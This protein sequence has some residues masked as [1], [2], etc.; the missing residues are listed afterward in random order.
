MP[1]A[2]APRPN[3]SAL[4]LSEPSGNFACSQPVRVPAEAREAVLADRG[5]SL[6]VDP[7]LIPANF[8][9]GRLKTSLAGSIPLSRS[10]DRMAR[11][12]SRVVEPGVTMTVTRNV[13]WREAFLPLATPVF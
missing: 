4:L 9:V 8:T 12:A 10:T 5:S 2:L 13:D 11:A 7:A 6:G 1:Y 3:R